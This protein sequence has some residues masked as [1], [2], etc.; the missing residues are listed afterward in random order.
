MLEQQQLM[1]KDVVAKL[2]QLYKT[3]IKLQIQD[4]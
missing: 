1:K 3:F 2:K 4:D